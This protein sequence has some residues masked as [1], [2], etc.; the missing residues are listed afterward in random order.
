MHI[1]IDA[2]MIGS[3]MPGGFRRYSELLIP[4]IADDQSLRLS[5]FVSRP[6]MDSWAGFPNVCCFVV[7][8]DCDIA[9]I[10]DTLRPDV[11]HLLTNGVGY[12]NLAS[13]PL[14]ITL[15]DLVVHI[16]PEFVPDD[17]QSMFKAEFPLVAARSHSIITVS[18]NTKYDL[19]RFY[20][21]TE[22]RIEVIPL[23]YAP[24]F[25]PLP[26]KWCLNEANRRFGLSRP[27]IL[28]VGGIGLRKNC[29]LLLKAFAK[30]SSKIKELDLVFTNAFI[31]PILH[32]EQMAQSSGIEDR[33]HFFPSLS[34]E[35]LLILYNTTTLMCFPSHHEGFGLPPLEAAACGARVAV[36]NRG[37]LPEV[38]GK[39]AFAILN[40]LD[41]TEWVD[42]IT[43][44]YDLRH[45]KN[46]VEL[47]T[48][49]WADIAK[50]TVAVYRKAAQE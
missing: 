43:Q 6:P 42:T 18:K 8:N 13:C 24:I 34:D 49:T 37:A 5:L 22:S 3:S 32:F 28:H 4:Q 33:V 7:K 47:Q 14:V 29:G 12:S 20:P 30:I 16:C 17:Y 40:A 9:S 45:Q 48:W 50:S 11:I 38:M 26:S 15:H 27:F 21:E 1:A 23:T 2:R 25:R 36:S 19:V 39:Y 10:C 35:D 44:A 31:T 41:V 46:P